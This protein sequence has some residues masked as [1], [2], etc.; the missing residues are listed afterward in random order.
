MVM[1]QKWNQL[2]KIAYKICWPTW[3]FLSWS[4]TT[5]NTCRVDTALGQCEGCLPMLRN[6]FSS[7]NLVTLRT[8]T[9]FWTALCMCYWLT[10]NWLPR[11]VRWCIK[12]FPKANCNSE[13]S[14]NHFK[15]SVV[16]ARANPRDLVA[17]VHG[18]RS[19]V[20]GLQAGSWEEQQEGTII[21]QVLPQTFTFTGRGVGQ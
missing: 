12:T 19:K 10:G 5:K 13:L 6:F 17:E 7:E 20:Q 2:T 15:L 11:P 18:T 4:Q 3:S 14:R 8:E 16:D 1:Q 9:D 21:S